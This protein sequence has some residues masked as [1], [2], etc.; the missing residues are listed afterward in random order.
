MVCPGLRDQALRLL[1]S[2]FTRI[3]HQE[4]GFR[5]RASR[6]RSRV[7]AC[8]FWRGKIV[9]PEL[10]GDLAQMLRDVVPSKPSPYQLVPESKGPSKGDPLSRNSRRH[11]P[12]RASE[13]A[14]KPHLLDEPTSH[15]QSR[16]LLCVLVPCALCLRGKQIHE[17]LFEWL[18][19]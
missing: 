12:S 18:P 10:L 13:A 8:C 5:F 17:A 11:A 4:R 7:L 14:G 19:H 16:A 1:V 2:R 15:D 9:A 6:L 3:Y